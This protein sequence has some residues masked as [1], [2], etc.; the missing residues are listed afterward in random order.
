M[1][2]CSPTEVRH[3]T[4]RLTFSVLDA[5]AAAMVGLGD[6]ADAWVGFAASAGAWV[7]FGASAGADGAVVAGAA[8]GA[9]AASRARPTTPSALTRRKFR[10]LVGSP[11]FI[12][13][14]PSLMAVGLISTATGFRRR[15]HRDRAG[16]TGGGTSFDSSTCHRATTMR[17]LGGRDPDGRSGASKLA[18]RGR[19]TRAHREITEG[20]HSGSPLVSSPP[21]PV[22]SVTAGSDRA[23]HED[24]RRR[25]RGV[26]REPTVTG[27]NQLVN[28]A[29]PRPFRSY[30]AP[31]S[32]RG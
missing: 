11:G 9:Q 31:S 32:P 16:A 7:G 25:W 19:Y 29:P 3:T 30:G 28:Q 4:V 23:G 18:D 8:A 6:A 17:V 14:T 24:G 10:R 20:A 22:R 1:T 13:H 2:F 26:T 27:A 15:R 5:A 12:T 21:P